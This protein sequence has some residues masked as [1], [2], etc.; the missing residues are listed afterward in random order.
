MKS[1]SVIAFGMVLLVG[2][3]AFS[4]RSTPGTVRPEVGFEGDPIPP[5]CGPKVC[6]SALPLN[7]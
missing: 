2:S 6:L 7:R 3:F 5:P 1:V 4:A